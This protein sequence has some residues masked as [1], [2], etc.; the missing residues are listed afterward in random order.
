MPC[1]RFPTAEAAFAR[2]LEGR[3]RVLALGETHAQKGTMDGVPSTT[4]RFTELF[5]PMLKG[6]ATDLVIELW[7]ANGSCGKKAEERVAT[8]QKAVTAPQA[9]TNQNE[10][11]ALGKAAKA[12]GIRPHVLVPPCEDY[13]RILDAGAGDVDAM[14]SMIAR[15]TAKDIHTFLEKT[16]G[17]EAMLVAYGGAMHNDVVPKPGHESWSFGAELSRKLGPGYVE[18]DLIV[19]EAI[20]DTDAWRALPWHPHFRP[21]AQ[22]D[23]AVLI[24]VGPGSYVIVFPRGAPAPADAGL[25]AP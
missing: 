3:P 20:R 6:R 22:G 2:V 24:T 14:L 15:L 21:Q 25:R 9:E 12:S 5:L 8:Q 1:E 11:V 4:R 17:K 16:E 10:F 18:L 13:A 19:P 7:V 23:G